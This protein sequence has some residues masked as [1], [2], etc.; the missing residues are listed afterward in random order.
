MVKMLT[1]ITQ[2]NPSAFS[3]AAVIKPAMLL[4]FWE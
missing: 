3:Q 4:N 2:I 1:Q